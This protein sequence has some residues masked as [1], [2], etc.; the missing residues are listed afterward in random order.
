[1]E[2]WI[3]TTWSITAVHIIRGQPKQ[4][5]HVSMTPFD[6]NVKYACELKEQIS[7]NSCEEIYRTVRKSTL[8]DWIFVL[9]VMKIQTE[10]S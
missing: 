3:A 2:L 8:H 4:L 10:N 7:N 1:M 6:V 5:V 9:N